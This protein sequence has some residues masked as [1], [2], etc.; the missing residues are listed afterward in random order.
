MNLAIKHPI[1][2]SVTVVMC[3]YNGEAHLNSQMQAILHQSLLPT[4]II[5]S[6]DGSADRTIEMVRDH[7]KSVNANMPGLETILL[8]N[9][10]APRGVTANFSSA[11]G[12][13][14][15]AFVVLT[16]QDDTWEH[17]RIAKGVAALKSNPGL[18]LIASDANLIN[19]DGLLDERSLFESK[20]ICPS[21]VRRLCGQSALP[22]LVRKNILPGMTFTMRRDLLDLALPIP[23]SWMH[24]Y[25]LAI[26]AAT[27]SGL[28]VLDDRPVN[29]RQH[30]AN[31]V[32][33]Q[34]RTRRQWA[35]RA[36]QAGASPAETVERYTAILNA[37]SADLLFDSRTTEILSS[38]LQFEV[39]RSEYSVRFVRRL[40][41]VIG[42]ALKGNYRRFASHGNLNILRDLLAP[43]AS[44]CQARMSGI[45]KHV[46]KRPS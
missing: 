18:L 33:A 37:Q 6:D 26:V 14:T 22:E 7:F 42:Q 11:L 2:Q 12:H 24:D 16:D 29:Y 43:I 45:R 30:G 31:V 5:V 20:R 10:G 40:R 17:D 15:G 32:G 21:Y 4:Q 25:W 28:N 13:S 41:Q 34:V 8:C 9:S 38:K 3:T 36:F 27:Q 1:A 23:E 39:S 46:E 44:Q 19:A 35:L